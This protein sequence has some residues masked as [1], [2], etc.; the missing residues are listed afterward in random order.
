[1]NW[2]DRN[3]YKKE[4][5]MKKLKVGFVWLTVYTLLNLGIWVFSSKLAIIGVCSFIFSLIAVFATGL[6]LMGRMVWWPSNL[7][8]NLTLS[9]IFGFIIWFLAGIC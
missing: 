5:K 2:I 9:A 8:K 6:I 7:N 1:M 4:K 3:P